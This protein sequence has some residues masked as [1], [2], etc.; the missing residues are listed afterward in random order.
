MYPLIIIDN[1]KNLLTILGLICGLNTFSCNYYNLSK[2]IYKSQMK[3]FGNLEV[4]NNFFEIRNQTNCLSDISFSMN[5]TIFLVE[6]YDHNIETGNKSYYLTIFNQNKNLS[7][8]SKIV[9]ITKLKLINGEY[10]SQWTK[11]EIEDLNNCIISKYK[12]KLIYEWDLV[13]IDRESLK[14]TVQYSDRI[15]IT[16]IIINKKKTKIDCHCFDDFFNL[17]KEYPVISD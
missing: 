13:K 6:I 12:K 8:K 15:Y 2:D 3:E 11:F 17:D 16:R 14:Y 4:L 1:M 10:K 7:F 5:D 9:N